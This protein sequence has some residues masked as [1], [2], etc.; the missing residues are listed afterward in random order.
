MEYALNRWFLTVFRQPTAFTDGTIS[1]PYGIFYTPTSD[2]FITTTKQLTIAFL[3]G[4]IGSTNN[5]GLAT[6]NGGGFGLSTSPIYASS[7]TY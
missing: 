6:V 7:T 2:I 5:G 1:S 3:L 4:T